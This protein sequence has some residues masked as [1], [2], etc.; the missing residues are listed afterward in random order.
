M[1]DFNMPPNV[2][3]VRDTARMA[4]ISVRSVWRLVQNGQFPTPVHIGRS[5]RWR[6]GDVEDYI[7]GLEAQAAEFTGSKRRRGSNRQIHTQ[8]PEALAGS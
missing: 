7:R 6:V 8:R 5:A 3:N 1:K 2:V 4:A